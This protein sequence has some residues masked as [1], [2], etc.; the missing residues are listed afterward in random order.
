M[1]LR[2]AVHCCCQRLWY[3]ARSAMISQH[4]G[5]DLVFLR[6]TGRGPG[7]GRP[8]RRCRGHGGPPHRGPWH[9]RLPGVRHHV[10]GFCF[11]IKDKQLQHTAGI[12]MP[13]YRP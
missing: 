1:Q 2:L 7:S 3:G 11:N 5:D 13:F 12:R 9:D 8:R 10:L 4:G 6:A